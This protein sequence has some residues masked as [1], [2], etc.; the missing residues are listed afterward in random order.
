ML[1][2]VGESLHVPGPS[3]EKSCLIH[4]FHA[5]HQLGENSTFLFIRGIKMEKLPIIDVLFRIRTSYKVVKKYQSQD[6]QIELGHHSGK[7]RT[8]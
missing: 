2:F 3:F 8:V 5:F 4:G 6:E 1:P 7:R